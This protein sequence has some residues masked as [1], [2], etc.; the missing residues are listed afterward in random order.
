ML[1]TVDTPITCRIQ[2]PTMFCRIVVHY[3]DHHASDPLLETN[4][5]PH[6]CRL[7]GLSHRDVGLRARTHMLKMS[8]DAIQHS[9]DLTMPIPH[10]GILPMK[11][12]TYKSVVRSISVHLCCRIV[13]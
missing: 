6:A 9:V 11:T 7:A 13:S 10:H 12:H 8:H 4:N 3:V 5:S 1:G 2:L